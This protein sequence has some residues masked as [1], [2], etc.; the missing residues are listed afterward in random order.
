LAGTEARIIN[1]VKDI[2]IFIY[3]LPLETAANH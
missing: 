2:N 1:E 3:K